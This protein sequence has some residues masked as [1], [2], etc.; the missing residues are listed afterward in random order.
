MVN[1]LVRYQYLDIQE[2]LGHI[3]IAEIMMNA[4]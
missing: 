3:L 4:A 2:S 1:L